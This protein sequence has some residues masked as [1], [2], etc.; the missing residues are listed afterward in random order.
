[1][2]FNLKRVT[3][4][5]IHNCP[6]KAKSVDRIICE[7]IIFPIKLSFD[8]ANK[9]DVVS[10]I[11]K[12]YPAS[13][14]NLVLIKLNPELSTEEITNCMKNGRYSPVIFYDGGDKYFLTY[15]R[16]RNDGLLA[17]KLYIVPKTTFQ[18]YLSSSCKKFLSELKSDL[19]DI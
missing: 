14:H 11:N 4:L 1:M 16:Y 5:I 15:E 17:S 6:S 8:F 7:S 10:K 12:K 9:S 13:L 18:K 3:Y 2:K 19:D